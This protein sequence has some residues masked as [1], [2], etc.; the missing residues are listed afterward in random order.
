MAQNL[1]TIRAK[2]A[3][4]TDEIRNVAAA[5]PPVDDRIDAVKRHLHKIASDA[6]N[7]LIER[8]ANVISHGHH[9]SEVNPTR[10]IAGYNAL[11][12]AVLALGPDTLLGEAVKLAEEQDTG[13][14]RMTTS[15]KESRLLELRRKR[16]S[17]ELL[18]AEIAPPSDIRATING[19]AMLGIPVDVAEEAG[20]L[21]EAR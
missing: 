14:L 2:V 20:F 10:D 17:L 11:G 3:D 9:I 7:R 16:Y 6:N 18:E 21:G 13:A 4:L 8:A 1:N 19:A 5:I 12:L 15:E